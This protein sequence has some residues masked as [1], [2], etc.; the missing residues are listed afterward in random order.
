MALARDRLKLVRENDTECKNAT[1]FK[2]CIF[3]ETD[4]DCQNTTFLELWMDD[5]LDGTKM[6]SIYHK[7]GNIA[8]RGT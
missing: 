5:D 7:N 8:E 2:L 1:F 3:S 4:T 6:H